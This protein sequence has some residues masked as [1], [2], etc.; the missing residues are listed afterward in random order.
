M[1]QSVINIPLSGSTN[2]EMIVISSTS[3]GS[4]I[5]LHTA[6]AGTG[7]T[8]DQVWLWAVNTDTVLH[9]VTIIWGGAYAVGNSIPVPVPQSSGLV[10]IAP[11]FPIQNS[12]VVSAF[13]D[14]ANKI[15]IIGYTNQI[16]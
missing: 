3:S 2:G 12:L 10:L 8:N 4:P 11:G 9:T 5:T 14:V 13:A 15:N 7:T 1:A 16:G 6:R